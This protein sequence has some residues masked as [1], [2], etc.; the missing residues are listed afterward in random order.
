MLA[1]FM[2]GM[3]PLAYRVAYTLAIVLGAIAFGR[4]LWRSLSTDWH[5]VKKLHQIPCH[6]CVFFTGDYHLKCPVHPYK[7]LNEEAI[8]C[9]D[10]R[11]REI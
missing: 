6:R 5:Y 11:S 8:D 1:S 10:F 3:F 4:S 9:M 2:D 7:A